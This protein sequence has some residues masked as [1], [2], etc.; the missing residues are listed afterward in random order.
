MMTDKS[1][2]KAVILDLDQTLTTDTGS[3][4]QFTTLLGADPK[5]HAEIYSRYKSGELNY[6]KAKQD[7]INLWKTTGKT[8][9]TDIK[10]IFKRIEL[11]DGAVQAIDYLKSKY[12]VSIISGAIDVFVEIFAKRLGIESYYA[13]TKFVFDKSGE[14]VDFHYTLSRGEEKLSYFDDF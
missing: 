9:K 14:L 12:V 7:L 1:K 6:Q 4:I 13:S 10:N 8:N 5:V 2:I 11:R 3:W